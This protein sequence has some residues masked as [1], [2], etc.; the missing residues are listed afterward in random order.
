MSQQLE[1]SDHM[2]LPMSQHLKSSDR[3][4][5]EMTRFCPK[6]SYVVKPASLLKVNSI[7]ENWQVSDERIVYFDEWKLY[8]TSDR[9]I[10]RVS[11][12]SEK[13]IIKFYVVKCPINFSLFSPRGKLGQ[14]CLIFLISA[15]VDNF[16]TPGLIF[17]TGLHFFLNPVFCFM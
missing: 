17:C 16:K 4:L 12:T 9:C 3:T 1:S 5:V 6:T 14:K 8:C 15:Y 7:K 10:W 13:P 2:A 11:L